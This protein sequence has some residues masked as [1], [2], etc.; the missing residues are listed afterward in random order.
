MLTQNTVKCL[1]NSRECLHVLCVAHKMRPRDIIF[2]AK[3]MSAFECQKMRIVFEHVERR[4]EREA[5][6]I[7]CMVDFLQLAQISIS[8]HA[9]WNPAQNSSNSRV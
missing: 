8:T 6:D 7:L 9:M 5:L 1:W 3:Q 4:S 2:I